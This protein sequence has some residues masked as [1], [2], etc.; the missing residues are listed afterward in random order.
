MNEELEDKLS[1]H[2]REAFDRLIKEK[3]PPPFLEERIVEML[4]QSNLIRPAEAGPSFSFVRIAAALAAGVALFVSGA[5]AGIWWASAQSSD[6]RLPQF[7]LV[8]RMT[9]QELRAVAADEER[10]RVEEYS[11]WARNVGQAG[12]LIGGEKLKDE[13]WLLNTV[14]GRAAISDRWP[15]S[16][17][18]VIA[19]YFLIQARDYE[20]AIRIAE[21]C[22][23]LKYG[24][25]VEVRQI[26]R[27]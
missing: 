26:E 3:M 21:G 5:V 11:A 27:F 25:T 24:G 12:A 16:T 9:P 4:K 7:M 23:H 17:E 19:G 14:D 2:E 10:S 18:K 6:T 8:L 1:P 22:P 20:Q 13:V 15:D